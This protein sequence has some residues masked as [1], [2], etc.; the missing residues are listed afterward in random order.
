MEDFVITLHYVRQIIRMI[1]FFLKNIII[2]G[3]GG[4]A[5]VA[6]TFACFKP[7]P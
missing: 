3:F 6:E 4:N 2:I 5:F 7:L 1:F